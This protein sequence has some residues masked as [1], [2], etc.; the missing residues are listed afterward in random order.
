MIRINQIRL[1]L[2]YTQEEAGRAIIKKARLKEGQLLS[3]D[4]LKESIDARKSRDGEVFC[5]LSVCA[6]ISGE[7]KFLRRNRSR[8][9]QHY[10][11]KIYRF[12]YQN[13]KNL[14][15][16]PVVI[17]TGPA[18]LFCALMLARAGFCPLV[19]ERGCDVRKRLEIVHSFWEGGRLDPQTNVQFGEGGAGTFSDGKLNTLVKDPSGLHRRVLEEFVHAGAPGDILYKYKPHLG[20]D[21]LTGIVENMRREIIS[22][23]GQVEFESCVTGFNLDSQG[24]IASVTVNDS[25]QTDARYVIL[26]VGHSAR[27][28]YGAL[29]QLGM[30]M[31]PKSFAIGVR[32]EHPQDM[33][34][35]AQYGA[36][37]QK[38]PPADYKLT[39]RAGDGRSVYT[40][41]MCPGGWV[42][43]SSSE[44]NGLVVNGMSYK[45]RDSQ[46]ANSAVI[47]SVR[48]QDF[49]GE[50]P[51]A[52]VRFQRKWDRLAW[53]EGRGSV[54]VQ[55]LGDFKKGQI[56]AAFGEVIPRHKGKISFGNI[57]N[58]LPDYVCRDLVEGI[59][60]FSRRL[61]DFNRE[62]AVLS[63]VET[64][65]SSPLRMLRGKDLQSNIK[66]IFPC[67]E[68]AGYAGG[69]TSA[70][71]DG[72]RAAQ[73]AA[74]YILRDTG[75]IG[76]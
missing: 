8:D 6:R 29:Y 27:D 50:D 54:P 72:I 51:L 17:G 43:D 30:Q 3:W 35:K 41:C 63:G 20:T 18:G 12:P 71:M 22:L 25:F 36:A 73:A 45:G 32:I 4:I 40:F 39:Y 21:A 26:A 66:G 76:E 1:R 69:I 11:P 19:L 33:V 57:R 14:E 49:E 58:C 52:G 15:H 61:A 46:T 56:S 9:I 37:A 34:D 59:D 67:G 10:E 2:G 42:V 64:R 68:G 47:V 62:D 38:L 24:H 31:E 28:T 53:Q 44:E 23:G 48:P 13:K 16:R 70:A 55:L 5:S 7:E 60:G 75:Q 74:E 65:T